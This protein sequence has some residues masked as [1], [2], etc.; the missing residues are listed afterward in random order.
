MVLRG[1]VR[2]LV[3]VLVQGVVC[4][5][6]ASAEPTIGVDVDGN[7]F[8]NSSS[9]GG[10]ARLL[11]NGVDVIQELADLRRLYAGRTTTASTTTVPT[12]ASTTTTASTV[13]TT[14]TA[15]ANTNV[16]HFGTVGCQLENVP[17][18]VTHIQGSFLLDECVQLRSTDLLI[19]S[20]LVYVSGN[21]RIYSFYSPRQFNDA[22]TNVD[23]LKR[24]LT[25]GGFFSLGYISGLVDINGLANI[26]SIGGV[27][28][29][30][31]NDDL[32][33]VDG[34]SGLTSIPGNVCLNDN[35]GLINIDGLANI[36]SVGGDVSLGYNRKLTN[37]N[38]FQSLT[39]I[40]G[41]LGLSHNEALSNVNG[42]ASVASVGGD[43]LCERFKQQSRLFP[44]QNEQH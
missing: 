17:S 42:F 35:N 31:S 7:L 40:G 8:I 14:T 32:I 18:G 34:L 2:C 33:N 27:L 29:L 19:F 26:T 22:V 20:K 15:P 11:L 3:A 21:F 13:L 30:A 24:T 23:G 38:G 28:N 4:A 36:T 41:D 9:S 6:L 44:Q 10:D 43:L 25:V 37:V 5:N 1:I 39:S 16:T 12:T